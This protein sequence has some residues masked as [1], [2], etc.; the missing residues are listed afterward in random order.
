[1]CVFLPEPVFAPLKP[2]G[3]FHRIISMF[4]GLNIPS[5]DTMGLPGNSPGGP[6]GAFNPLKFPKGG[7]FGKNPVLGIFGA[8]KFPS[9]YSGIF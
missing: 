7:V 6:Y 9:C 8:P 2:L 1:M 5:G 4:G 3:G